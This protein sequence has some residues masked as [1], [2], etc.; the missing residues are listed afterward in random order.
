MECVI[1]F[2]K[3]YLTF[4]LLN[5]TPKLVLLNDYPQL[6]LLINRKTKCLL[7]LATIFIFFGTVDL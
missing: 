6:N 5:L 4:L 3:L 2:S 1:D 7:N